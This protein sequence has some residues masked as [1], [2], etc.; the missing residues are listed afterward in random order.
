VSLIAEPLTCDAQ[1][2]ALL[3]T[4]VLLSQHCQLTRATI[5]D[6]S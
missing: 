6:A 4:T 3:F 5:G 2:I 1:A